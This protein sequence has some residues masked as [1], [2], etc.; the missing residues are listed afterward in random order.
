L[1]KLRFY[2]IIPEGCGSKIGSLDFAE[3]LAL[4]VG[5]KAN[6]PIVG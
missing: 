1:V 3:G 5:A 2:L 6:V 4:C